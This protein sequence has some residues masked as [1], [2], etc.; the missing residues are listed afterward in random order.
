MVERFL[1]RN[2]G[3]ARSGDPGLG[4]PGGNGTALTLAQQVAASA[5]R[6]DVLV[7]GGLS[8]D[9]MAMVQRIV[10]FNQPAH[11]AAGYGTYFDL[12]IVGQARLGLDTQLGNGASFTSMVVGQGAL[13]ATYLGFTHPFELPDRVIVGRDPVGDLPHL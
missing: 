2:D 7:P 1:T 12:F 10:A 9:Q 5:H 13:A 3:G 8:A 11:T 4:P 6:F